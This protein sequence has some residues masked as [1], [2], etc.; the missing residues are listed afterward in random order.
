[1]MMKNSE[2]NISV[3]KKVKRKTS[4]R[5]STVCQVTTARLGRGMML[6]IIKLDKR[7]IQR[8]PWRGLVLCDSR[9]TRRDAPP[10]LASTL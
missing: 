2:L 10:W 9:H 3:Q 8:G 1:V 6:E 7:I 4:T 5:F